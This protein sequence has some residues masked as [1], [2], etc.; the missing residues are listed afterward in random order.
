ME[1]LF[2]LAMPNNAWAVPG[3]T[4]P[5]SSPA[6]TKT[7]MKIRTQLPV[8]GCLLGA[9]VANASTDYGPA[10]W[11]ANCGQYYTSGNGHKF[12]VIHDMEGYYASTI[13]YFQNC[14]TT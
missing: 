10:V 3:T 13:S 6:Q 8:I 11:K 9:T 5:I 2:D 4:K 7:Q 14:S 1:A 12:A